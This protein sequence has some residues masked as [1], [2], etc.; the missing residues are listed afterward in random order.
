MISNR[1]HRFK[2]VILLTEPSDIGTGSLAKAIINSDKKKGLLIV[3]DKEQL[4]QI[5][6]ID[7]SRLDEIKPNVI[8]HIPLIDPSMHKPVLDGKTARRY[9]RRILM[10]QK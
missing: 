6:D 7:L 8:S 10:K 4:K 5:Q 9:R 3:Q 2:Q 1:T